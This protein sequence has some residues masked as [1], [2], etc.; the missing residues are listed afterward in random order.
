M[1]KWTRREFVAAA[2]A[3]G[4]MARTQPLWGAEIE[5]ERAAGASAAGTLPLIIS[6]GN[7]FSHLDGGMAVLKSGGDALDAVLAVVT[8]VEDDPNVDTVG[9]GG[10]PNEDGVVQLDACV[11][12]GPTAKCG[13]VGAIE[14]I[15]NPSLVARVVM[16]RTNHTFL[17][18][19]GATEFAVDEGF[20]TM[21]LLTDRSRVAWLA[22][23][24]KS[25]ENWRPG[26]DSP[27]WK[28]HLSAWLDTPEKLAWKE[29]IESVVEHPPT[30]TIN[31]L[32][33]DAKGNISGTTT[34]SGLA[35][36]ING[37]VGDSPII[38]A[39]LFVDNE[40]GAAGSTGRGEE[41]I[42]IA[43]GH[44][45]VE[46]MRQGMSPTDACLEALRRVQANYKAF[47]ERLD[48]FHLQFYAI[49]KDG[50]HGASTLW[51]KRKANGRPFEYAVHDGTKAMLVP[52]TPLFDK[53]G[54]DY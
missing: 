44:T 20:E 18:G 29:H 53:P 28:A 49:N 14:K 32:A 25:S 45:I 2:L 12:H 9:Y 30:G 38:G 8:K 6:A 51:A 16:E 1:E 13:A 42:K 10:L 17:V 36:K 33:V 39:G 54:G 37:R 7:G 43:G 47:P 5:G 40:V 31:C 19:P 48:D 50:Q 11:M 21:N 46:L 52:C 15:K 4:A 41:N 24:A 3:G 35:W 26:L 27:E 22:W 23:K 34:T